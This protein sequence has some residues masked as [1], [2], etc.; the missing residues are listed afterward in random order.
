VAVPEDLPEVSADAGLLERV[1]ANLVQN[2]LRYA[3]EGTNVRLAGSAHAGRVELRVIDRGPG[4][5]RVDS[6]AV[7][8]AFQRR[9]DSPSSGAG[10]GL[11]L[12]IARGFAEAMGGT[13][14]SE[15]TPGGGATLVVSLAQAKVV[16]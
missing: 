14:T 11:G 15:E 12:A 7:F 4:I 3:P 1:I 13:V 6:D 10:V 2:A 16:R 8:A 5:A 9:D